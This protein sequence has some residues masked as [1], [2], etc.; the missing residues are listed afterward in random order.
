M[1][2]TNEL[3]KIF[4]FEIGS[5]VLYVLLMF[6]NNF[7][8]FLEAFKHFG[9]EDR[10]IVGL[11]Y[12]AEYIKEEALHERKLKDVATIGLGLVFLARNPL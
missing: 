7:E 5:D 11:F 3:M 6:I 4:N 2:I 1:V 8:A 9:C 12:I 10:I